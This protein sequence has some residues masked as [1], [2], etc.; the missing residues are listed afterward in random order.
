VYR[1][2]PALPAA[3]GA[4]PHVVIDP[5]RVFRRV[6]RGG[7]RCYRAAFIVPMAAALVPVGEA[8]HEQKIESLILPS[9]RRRCERPS[10]QPSE[11]NVQ[12]ALLD[13][14]GHV[15]FS[16]GLVPIMR[17]ELVPSV[18]PPRGRPVPRHHPGEPAPLESPNRHRAGARTFQPSHCRS[19]ATTCAATD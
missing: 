5:A 18:L 13:L 9:G 6:Q 8:V 10:G 2:T 12:Q 1:Y 16:L 11:V 14:V 17:P 7:P 3:A 19:P 4:K 15:R